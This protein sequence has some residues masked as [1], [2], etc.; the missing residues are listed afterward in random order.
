MPWSV[1]TA[2][3]CTFTRMKRAPT[4]VAMARAETASE[5]RALIPRGRETAPRISVATAAMAATQAGSTRPGEKGTS[6]KFSTRMASTPPSARAWASARAAWVTAFIEPA[7]RGL[8]G[9]GSRWTMPTTAFGEPKI[10]SR[11]MNQAGMAWRNRS[12]QEYSDQVMAP[13]AQAA[14]SRIF[15]GWWVAVAFSLIIFLSTGIRFAV[16]PFLKPVVGDLGIDRGAFSLVVSL[17]LFLY[18]LFVPLIGPLV[19]RWGSRRVCALGTVVMAIA[20]GLTSTVHTLWQFALYYGVLA[21]LGLAATGQVVASATLSRW[22]AKRRGTAVSALSVASM[23]GISLLVPGVMWSILR[24]GWRE[25]FVILGVVSLVFC[26]PIAL[27]VVRDDPE[28]MGLHPDG[29]TPDPVGPDV[30]PAIERTATGDAVR[31]PSFWLLSGGLFSCGFSMSLLSAHGVPMLTDHGFHSMTA[32]TAMGLT[33]LSSIA[34]GMIIGILSDRWGRKPMLAFVYVLRVV[35]FI[36]IFFTRD[37]A[38]LMLVVILAGLSPTGS[39]AMASALTADIFGRLSVGS[40]FGLI[41]LVHQIGSAL[42]SWLSG[43]LFDVSGGYGIAFAVACG[44]LLVGAGLALS[45][46]VNG[47]PVRRELQPVAGGR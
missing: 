30:A 25:T 33:G 18:G 31:M 16:G 21:A 20:M 29:E 45:I 11:L 37:P 6:P 27:L 47:R 26:L 17:S 35:A 3:V 14:E 1:T 44:L 22:F 34:A 8:P 4:A 15:Y 2:P 23:A 24:F 7:Q 46:D 5:R 42:G 36:L 38:V 40:I 28:R 19:D 32:S 9:S 43:Y 13:R 39:F 10:A 12:M 41:F